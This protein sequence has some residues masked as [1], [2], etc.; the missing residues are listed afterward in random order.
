[1]DETR[2]DMMTEYRGT[3]ITLTENELPQGIR[4]DYRFRVGGYTGAGY[5]LRTR[6]EAEREAR[7]A[8]D[9]IL[10]KR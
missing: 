5:G 8:I 10:G 4:W 6:E 1:M 3:T 9:G 2:T 7:R